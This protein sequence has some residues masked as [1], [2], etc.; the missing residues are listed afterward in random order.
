MI[1]ANPGSRVLPW[2][3]HRRHKE[4]RMLQ[5][6]HLQILVVNNTLEPQQK[7]PQFAHK[8]LDRMSL[9]AYL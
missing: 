8:M 2:I 7:G 5:K 1:N 9:N 6:S 3:H 4:Q